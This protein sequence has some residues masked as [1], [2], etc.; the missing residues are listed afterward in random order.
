MR[1]D[2]VVLAHWCADRLIATRN[3]QR[4][5]LA[6]GRLCRRRLD[7]QL[8]IPAESGPE[9]LGDRMKVLGRRG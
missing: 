1:S 2:D 5:L 4:R 6:H 3:P 9:A 8:P 7:H